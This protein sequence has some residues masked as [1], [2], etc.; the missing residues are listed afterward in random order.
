MSRF[1][2][3]LAES[4]TRQTQ[5]D[6]RP[7]WQ[8]RDQQLFQAAREL[9]DTATAIEL[10]IVNLEADNARLRKGRKNKGR[11]PMMKTEVC[12]EIGTQLLGQGVPLE[13]VQAA[14]AATLHSAGTNRAPRAVAEVMKQIT[15]RRKRTP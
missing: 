5:W 2:E 13:Q 1:A 4:V 8:L 15:L 14:I 11:A 9:D 10:R 12:V 7:G 6:P 3:L